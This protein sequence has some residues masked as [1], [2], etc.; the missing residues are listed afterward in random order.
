M[1][2]VA[3]AGPRLDMLFMTVNVIS[4][5]ITPLKRYNLLLTLNTE[6]RFSLPVK[7]QML[8]LVAKAVK[9][10]QQ[11]VVHVFDESIMR[12]L[13]TPWTLIKRPAS[14]PNKIPVN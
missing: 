7:N 12:V 3:Y 4:A 2:I 8:M 5:P 9:C 14:N 6:S 10:T 13:K 11:F 1:S